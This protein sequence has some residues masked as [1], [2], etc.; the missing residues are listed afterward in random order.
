MNELNLNGFPSITNGTS[1]KFGPDGRLYVSDYRGLIMVFTIE[2][3]GPGNYVVTDAEELD[4]ITT[5]QDHNDDGSLFFS[6]SRETLGIEVG[7]TAENPI[8]YVASSDF[9]IGGFGSGGNGD[10][11]LDTNSGIITRISWTGSEWDVV[12]IVRGLPRSE[13]NHASNGLEL[14]QINGQEYLLIGQGGHTNA[15][16]PSRN[17]AY[18]GEYALT[19]ALLSVDLDALESMPILDDNGRKYIYDLPTLD[20]PSRPNANGIIDPDN[21]G[22]DGVDVNDPFGGNDGLNQ[23]V[24][25]SGGPVQVFSPGHRNIYDFV[26]TES[27]AVYITDN[28]AN[29]GWGGFPFGEGT[30]NVTNN[31]N[32]L[33]PGSSSDSGGESVNNRD[34]L[35]MVTNNIN[36][37]AP[38]SFYGGHAN[39]TRANPLGAGL[40]TNP[41]S[42]GTTNG[43]VFRTL[44]YDPDGSTPGSTTNPD[45]GLPANWP[46]VPVAMANPVEGDWRG[47]GINNPDGD[48][49]EI[50][51]LWGTN[52]NGIDEYTA[53]N[54][55]GAMQGDLI[56]GV[57]TG[58][59]RR[60]QLN[61]DGS[62]QNLTSNFLSGLEGNALGVTCNSDTDIFPGSI[63]VATLEGGIYVFEPQD[64]IVCN[65]PSTPGYATDDYDFDGY[66]NQDEDEN[67]SDPCNG[68]SQPND[69]DKTAGGTLVSDLNDPDDDND[70]IPDAQDPFQLGDPKDSGTDAFS[71]PVINQMFSSNTELKGYLG[72]GFTGMMNNG[73]A[74]PNWL[75]WLD[76]RDD[77]SDPNPNDILGGAIGAMTM[78]L[79]AGTALGNAN[80]QEKAFQYGVESDITTTPYTIVSRLIN[81]TDNLQLYHAASPA[82]GELGIFMGDGTQSNYIKFVITQAGLQVRQE[83]ADSEQTPIE[84]T[85]APGNRPGASAILYFLVDPSTGEIGLE[86]AF[87]GGPRQLLGSI[88]AQGAVLESIQQTGNPLAVGLIGT[89]NTTGVELEGTWDYLNVIGGAPTIT[90]TI[91]DIHTYINSGS[92]TFNL[93]NYFDDDN[94]NQNLVY[95]VSGN[96]DP[97]IGAQIN[98]NILTLNYPSTA[99]NSNITIRA[100]DQDTNFTEFTFNINVAASPVIYRVNAGGPQIAA[101]DGGI[102][103]AADTNSNPNEYLIQWETNTVGSV[104]SMQSFDTSVDLSTTPTDIFDTS[105][106]DTF[107]SIPHVTYSFPVSL[108]GLYEIRLYMGEGLNATSEAGER[109]FDVEV[110]GNIYPNMD[111]IDLSGT[112]GFRNGVVLSQTIEVLDDFINISLINFNDGDAVI[113]G[114]EIIESFDASNPIDIQQLANQTN[115]EGEALNGSL[116]VQASG[117]DGN[118]QYSAIG[119]PPGITI[120]PTN[121]QIGGTVEMGAA[122]GSPYNVTIIVDDTDGDTEDIE[123]ITFEWVI[124]PEGV[125]ELNINAGGPALTHNGVDYQQDE[126]FVGGDTYENSDAQLP[127][128][129]Q[130]E[131]SSSDQF[132]SYE[133][134]VPNG[135]YIV[136]LHIAELYWGATG[137]G[138]GGEGLRVFDVTLEGSLV[139]DDYDI[140]ADVG[141]ETPTIKSYPVTVNDGILNLYLSALASDG[142]VD[143]PKLSAIQISGGA[144]TSSP[145]TALAEAT[146]ESGDMP[147]EVSF[148]GSNSTDDVAVVQYEWNFG[149]GSPVSNEA[150]PV[151]TYTDAGSYDA[152]LTVTDGD[153]QTDTDTVTT[154]VNAVP[155]GTEWVL[156]NEDQN[157]TGRHECSFVQV[158]DKFYLMGGRESARTLDIY[159]YASDSWTSLVDSAPFEFNHFQATEYQG[160]IWVIG[161]FQANTFPEPPA[162]FIWA[163][164]PVNEEWIQGP[165]IPESR[166]RGSAGLVVYDDKFYIIGGNTLGHAG[167]YVPWFDEY[168]PATGVWTA[169]ED[170]DAPRARDHF[171]AVVIDDNL[172]AVGGRQSGGDGGGFKPVL[173]EVDVFNFTSGSWST[174]GADLPTPRAAPAVANFNGNLLVMGGEVR[175]EIVY[176]ENV[177]DALRITESYDPSTGEWT[178]L[179]DM[180]FERHGFQAIVSGTGVYVVAGS[181]SRGGGNQKNMEYFGTDAPVGVPG[182]ASILSA[183]STVQLSSGNNALVDVDASGGNTGVYVTEMNITGPDASDFAIVSGAMNPGFI[184]A[185]STHQ[186]SLIYTGSSSDATADLVIDYGIGETLTIGLEGNEGGV[187]GTI[188][189]EDFEDLTNGATVDNGATAWTS[190]RDGGTFEVLDGQFMARGASDTPGV[191]TSEVIAI[192]GT[193]SVSVDVDDVNNNKEGDDFV[194]ALYILDGGTPVEFGSVSDDI[195]PQTFT[196]SGLTGS[197]VQVVVEI[198]V[199]GNPEFYFIDNVTVTG[200]SVG[201]TTYALTVNSGSGDGSYESGTVVNIVADPAPVGEQFEAWTGDV[202]AVAEVNS[203]ST[204]VT[205]PSSA[206]SITAT[207]GTIPSGGTIWLEDFEDLTNGATVDNGATAWTSTRDGGTFEVFDGQFM[208]RGASDTPGVWTSEVIAI[209]GTVSV[210]VDV[211]DVNNNKE[212]DDFLRALYILDGGTPVEFGSVSDDIDPQTF[213]ASGLTG[214]TIQIVVEM[215]VSGNPEFYFIDNVTVTGESAG[216]TTYALTVNSGSGDGIYEAGEVVNI[217]ADPAPVG[218]QFEAWTGDIGAV[219]DVNSASTTVTMPSSAVSVTATYSP[220]GVTTY[221]LTVN[222]GSGD[223]SYE[224]GEVVNIVADAAP[225]GQQF[226]AWTGDVG[227]VADVNSASTTVTMPSSAVSVTATYGTIPLGGTIWLED[228]EDLTNGTTVDNGATAWTSTRDGGTF[229]VFDG[230]FMANGASDTPGVW[231]SE[232]IAIGETVSVSVDVDDDR[233]NKEGDDFLRALY[234][235]DGGTPVEFGSVSDDIDPQ[236][237]TASGLT[238]STIQIVVEMIVS[239]NP[240]FYFIDNVTVTGSSPSLTARITDNVA[241]D[242]D[243]NVQI[244]PYEIML[245]PNPGTT[246]VTLST[247]DSSGLK[248]IQIFNSSGQLVGTHNALELITGN[249]TYVLPITNLQSGVYHLNILTEDG[250]IYFKQL[251][252]KK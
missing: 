12:D 88:T 36:T 69:F 178:R 84:L 58:R 110:E 153:D 195:D 165:E 226:E 40:Y 211:D 64:F 103:W 56:A 149:D 133:I 72:L 20:D 31:Y 250:E 25:V 85:I 4:A 70:G 93:N 32:P 126:Y 139:L 189:M 17:F 141:P 183:P 16:S 26:V 22:Y 82:N 92:D 14:A 158:G 164:D 216:G 44:V 247:S 94:G 108:Q 185:N 81:F 29:Q 238:G 43:A 227:A 151:H 168:D 223:G 118:L 111:D 143:Q 160:L 98:G 201:G 8:I 38:G 152:V 184:K 138:T 66:T 246:E 233:D 130:T 251:V 18:T 113:S 221:A 186:L 13:E 237:F 222:N 50:I 10:S 159:D 234:I 83:I 240:E 121:G 213:T 63:W 137:G 6:S 123:S 239:G 167:G 140:T 54:F 99:A 120:E 236:T 117:G 220:I 248:A 241:I 188:W 207:Y 104:Q 219:A 28:G 171:H 132:Y 163:F 127:P 204:T 109:V 19:A 122:T 190:T 155:I 206:V 47:P 3:N 198:I 115:Q 203:A 7:G 245:Y 125:F 51:T 62:L 33:Q 224:S 212:G 42:D 252:V 37:Y 61:P 105:R 217:V 180:N 156:K 75:Q 67:G 202:G 136:Q 243:S 48:D 11:G 235:L 146:P 187:S 101:L 78:Q 95:S 193:V 90:G 145:P 39:P 65:P 91:S 52:T 200:E 162:D 21:L 1:I 166:K 214:S 96:T 142:G 210:S 231:T 131:R 57:N 134:P 106:Y 100:T 192:G 215:I 79:T 114:I 73:D 161:A 46:P 102:S 97:S 5:I 228:F 45:L 23:A 191:W 225:S 74:N 218:E 208:A 199:S 242:M 157:Y 68:G 179:E 174:L 244:V 249:N 89:S 116:F 76:R 170:L 169:L 144:A 9:R 175:D 41:S 205:M 172:Y 124:L 35:K 209:G 71:I 129:Y 177:D 2:R 107:E 112:Y 87:D 128:L 30:G 197:T 150:D 232:V 86:Y 34:N 194:R 60:V 229:E 154:T 135:D 53:S 24:L 230:R 77:P 182:T 80:S 15:G 148:T 181:P 147:L 176:G 27:G 173:P 55:G 49:A 59:L 119:L 196:A